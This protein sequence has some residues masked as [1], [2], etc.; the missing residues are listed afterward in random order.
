MGPAEKGTN[1]VAA[2]SL[3]AFAGGAFPL[4]V[5]VVVCGEVATTAVIIG[6]VLLVRGLAFCKMVGCTITFFFPPM[7]SLWLRGLLYLL[8][9]GSVGK[10]SAEESAVTAAT[11]G[12]EE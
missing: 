12:E 7:F 6:E 10:I 11:K 1:T 5:A 3:F 4:L 2:P 8:G 9:G